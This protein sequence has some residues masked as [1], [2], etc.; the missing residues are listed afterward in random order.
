MFYITKNRK[1]IQVR[2]EEQL[3]RAIDEKAKEL[4]VSRTMALHLAAHAFL[5]DGTGHISAVEGASI[6]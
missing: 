3:L 5:T 6:D 4:R 2:F 1:N